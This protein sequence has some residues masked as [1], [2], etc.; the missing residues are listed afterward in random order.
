VV[1]KKEKKKN[2]N[3]FEHQ[4][5]SRVPKVLGTSEISFSLYNLPDM[6]GQKKNPNCPILFLSTLENKFSGISPEYQKNLDSM[7]KKFIGYPNFLP[8]TIEIT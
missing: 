1:R 8:K 4:G 7:Q 2:R 3:F 6:I 5:F